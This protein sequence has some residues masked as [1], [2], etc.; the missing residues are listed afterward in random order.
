VI[1]DW[2]RHRLDTLAPAAGLRDELAAL[3]RVSD[4]AFDLIRQDSAAPQ[5]L[6]RL[7]DDARGASA[8]IDA[9]RDVPADFEALRRFRRDESLRIA[10]RDALDLDPV[11][12]TLA[13]ISELAEACLDIAIGWLRSGMA[14][15]HGL[16]RDA[17]GREVGLAVLGLGKLG[18]A[19]LNFSSDIDLIYAYAEGGDSDGARPLANEDWFARLGQQLARNLSEVT[20]SGFVHRVDLR[21]RPFGHSGRI[22][23]SFA[24]AEQYYQREGRDW[25][26]YAWIKAR[27]V[28]GDR[29]A[30]AR[31]IELLRPFVYRRYLDF[32]AIAGMREMKSMIE[33]EVA[34]RERDHDLKLGRG[35]IREIEFVV[36]LTQLIRGGREP[37]LRVPGTL[38]A[39]A[40]AARLEHIEAGEA[41]RLAAAYRFLRRLENRVQML[42]DDQTHTLPEDPAT[43]LRLAHGLGLADSDALLEA[44]AA[45]RRAVRAAFDRVFS[46]SGPPSPPPG[47]LASLW[48]DLGEGKSVEAPAALDESALSRLSQ[49]AQ[50]GSVQGLSARARARLDR[51]MPA[52]MAAAL[53]SGETARLLPALLDLVTVLA[54]RSSYLA[55]LDEHPAALSRLVDVFRQSAL[56]AEQ[57]TRHPVLLDEL[58]GAPTEDQAA[59]MIDAALGRALTL[60]R[61]GDLES[62]LNALHEV[63]AQAGFRLGLRR[64]DGRD[65][66]VGCARGLAT[67]ADRLV[68]EVWRLAEAEMHARHGRIVAG[69]G[70]GAA[71]LGYGSLGGRELGFSSDLD[72]VFLYDPAALRA[73]SDGPRPLDPPSY[74]S[75]LAQKL[76]HLISSTGPSGPLYE[77][78]VRLRPEGARGLL[79]V[80]LEAFA[81][82][83]RERARTWE[84]Q[85]LVR[86]RW[87]CG[88]EGPRPAFEAIRREALTRPRD[89]LTLREDVREM[90]ERLRS[91]RDRSSDGLFDLKQGRGGLVDLEFLL[92]WAV[93][94]HGGDCPAL[95]DATDNA[96][97]LERLG[98]HGLLEQA[99]TLAR[100]HETLL[101]A[102]L[103]CT[104]QG[105]SRLV[106]PSAEIA[107]A[108]QAVL[109]GWRDAGLG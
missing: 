42:G 47:A 25:E 79:V 16:P 62:G 35:G 63:K 39:L 26:R 12:V 19:E 76:V 21:L 69:A 53:D 108:A 33:A 44:L 67:L 83:Q 103:A 34:R 70:S 45:E 98:A 101:A 64:L 9:L 36:Q 46:E 23:A 93:L 32:P 17:Q 94:T 40:A 80:S 84:H 15:R 29:A 95:L 41:R 5:R 92:Q 20:A 24:A 1:E 51:L 2:L 81:T 31:L 109:A 107:G 58:L 60:A 22:A 104:L 30:G 99:P 54:R 6:A 52:L 27:P 102:A 28:A 88:A 11:E 90:R 4:V 106:A 43:R 97:L 59:A 78:D 56:M 61:P 100:A 105:R 86:A 96:A 85:A 18:G 49:L 7:R 91:E 3:L 48:R 73:L 82:Y 8:R 75:R 68:A 65:D 13:Q 74:F 55:L 71:V 66:A 10:W 14:E 57:V 37:E 87:L 38:A 72:L 89:A 50:S 77:V